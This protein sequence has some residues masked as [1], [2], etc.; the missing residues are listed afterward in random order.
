MKT[1]EKTA[2]EMIK[3]FRDRVVS[4]GDVVDDLTD[5]EYLEIAADCLKASE[6][7]GWDPAAF[8]DAVHHHIA[9]RTRA[10]AQWSL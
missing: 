5:E 1:L 9:D 3:D 4:Q 7:A 6:K 10:F 2:V 8:L